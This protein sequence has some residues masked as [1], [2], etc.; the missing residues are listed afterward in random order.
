L[1]KIRNP[2]NGEK[3]IKQVF[4]KEEIYKGDQLNI[5]PDIIYFLMKVMRFIIMGM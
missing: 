5:A 4:F 1:E 3:L 2:K